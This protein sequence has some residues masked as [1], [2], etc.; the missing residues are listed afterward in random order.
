MSRTATT[1]AA[2]KKIGNWNF[3][4]FRESNVGR[5]IRIAVPTTHNT[6]LIGQQRTSMSAGTKI[7]KRNNNA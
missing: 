3:F 5:R 1:T 7:E 4:L 6:L 2:A